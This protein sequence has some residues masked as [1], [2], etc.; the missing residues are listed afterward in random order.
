[1]TGLLEGMF[2][3]GALPHLER[4]LA[5]AAA[6]HLLILD[7]VAN[8]DTPGY[9]RKDL[10]ARAFEESLRA[11]QRDGAVPPRPREYRQL[12]G[13][14]AGPSGSISQPGVL[15]HDG[16]D[17]DVERELAILGKNAVLHNSLAGLLR[18]SFEQIRMAITERP[19]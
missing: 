10:D 1:M 6:R 2:S 11:A 3:G 18:N 16:N 5:F 17:V 15:R 12:R 7:N 4:T 9:R 19:T 14:E 8:A 13:K